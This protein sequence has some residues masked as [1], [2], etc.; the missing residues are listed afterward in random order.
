[1]WRVIVNVM[2]HHH[3]DVRFVTARFET[4]NG[5]SNDEIVSDAERLQ[6]PI[7]YCNGVQKSQRCADLGWFVDIWIDDFPVLIPMK[8]ELECILQ[9]VKVNDNKQR[10]VLRKSDEDKW[11][12]EPLVIG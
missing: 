5:Y 2:K 6:I 3:C 4:P 12:S 1:M 7:I 11:S 10:T 9:G 8:K